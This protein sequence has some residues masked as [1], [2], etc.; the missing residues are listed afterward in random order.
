[1]RAKRRQ[2]TANSSEDA[3]GNAEQDAIVADKE[4]FE[5]ADGESIEVEWK[6]FTI[7]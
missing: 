5:M 2:L 1:M 3:S 6:L 7:R 4:E